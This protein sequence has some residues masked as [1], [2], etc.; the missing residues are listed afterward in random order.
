M[1]DNIQNNFV[2]N[3]YSRF[4]FQYYNFLYETEMINKSNEKVLHKTNKI[5]LFNILRNFKFITYNIYNP[6]FVCSEPNNKY[7]KKDNSIN[8]TNLIS[9]KVNVVFCV[10]NNC[11]IIEH[12]EVTLFQKI[13]TKLKEN[14]VLI[15]NKSP[16]RMD[17]EENQ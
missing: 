11:I 14:K 5:L 16:K 13:I 15:I 7:T 1:L 3:I 17:R 12:F 6:F 9:D 2:K 4:S 8:N 10:E